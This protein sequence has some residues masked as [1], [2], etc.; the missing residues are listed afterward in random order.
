MVEPGGCQISRQGKR[1]GET[2]LAEG[3]RSDLCQQHR[4]A[5]A[6]SHG[7][8]NGNRRG[9]RAACGFGAGGRGGAGRSPGRQ[10]GNER[11]CR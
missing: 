3:R 7:R 6:P 2:Q 10:A 11:T 5:G 8:G 4:H 1:A 9:G